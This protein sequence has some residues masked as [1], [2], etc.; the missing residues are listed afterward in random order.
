M[1]QGIQ[2]DISDGRKPCPRCKQRKLLSEFGKTKR[3]LHGISTYCKL[4][5]NAMQIERRA[6]PEGAQ[7]H[8]DASKAW[9]EA[10]NERHRDNNARWKYGIDH[11]TYETMLAAQDGKCAICKTTEPGTGM[12]RFAI[13]HC[14]GTKVVRGLL[15]NSC[16]NGLGRF[17]DDPDRL[18][19]A[20]TYLESFL[21]KG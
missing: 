17:K 3:T 21:P 15:C 18:L 14:H 9:R 10:N 16:N 13:D 6:T 7:K 4:C 12:E 8:R 11:G 19:K 2:H 5:T 1:V 20:A